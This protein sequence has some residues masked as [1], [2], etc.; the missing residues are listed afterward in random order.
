MMEF[1]AYYKVTV[2]YS[3][4]INVKTFALRKSISYIFMMFA[5]LICLLHGLDDSKYN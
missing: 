3:L 2:S 4:C 1:Y 5:M